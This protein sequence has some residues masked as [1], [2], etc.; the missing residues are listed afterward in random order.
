MKYEDLNIG[1]RIDYADA[2]EL[3]GDEL[4]FEQLFAEPSSSLLLI[5]RSA[6]IGS[7]VENVKQA[8]VG[9]ITRIVDEDDGPEYASIMLDVGERTPLDMEI[10]D[11]TEPEDVEQSEWMR[12]WNLF[13]KV[14]R[15]RTGSEAAP[16]TSEAETAQTAPAGAAPAAGGTELIQ[17]A[18]AEVDPLTI[19]QTLHRRI[20]NDA[21]AA[22]ESIW[23]LCTAIKEMRDGKHYK[24]LLYANFEGYCEDGLGMSR[25]QAYRYI[26]IAEGMTPENVSSMR[27]IGTTKLALLASVTEEQREVIAATA[28]LDS[29]TVRELKAQVEALK[30]QADGAEKSRQD[31]EERARKWYEKVTDY[32]HERQSEGKRADQLAREARKQEQKIL[33]LQEKNESM[34]ANVGQLEDR[35]RELESRP[36]EVAVQTDDAALEQLRAEHRAEIEELE[37]EIDRTEARADGYGECKALMTVAK[38]TLHRIA[39]YFLKNPGCPL[40]Y[41]IKK[42]MGDAMKEIDCCTE[43]AKS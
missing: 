32:D 22:A 2:P 31:A 16:D 43:E 11:M 10:E 9:Q 18:P 41:D 29:V 3:F 40:K 7:T 14:W 20:V 36:V 25:A 38:D 35:I 24:A 30:H 21:Q 27:Q 12:T 37:A 5:W 42:M 15:V 17:A 33:E 23:D 4:S 39:L 13:D 19:A 28:D 1:D 26:A 8:V 34:A 6:Y